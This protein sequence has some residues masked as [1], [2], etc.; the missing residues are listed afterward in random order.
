MHRLAVWLAVVSA[1]VFVPA[2]LADGGP[3]LVT[4][5]GQGVATRDGAFHYVAVPD[6]ARTLLEK[7][8]VADGQVNYWLPLKG[9]WGIPT[10][11]TGSQIGQGLSWNGRT[12]VLAEP[13]GY[14][15][16]SRFLLVDLKRLRAV[17]TITLHGFFSFDALSPDGS[18]MYLIQ[19]SH[20][21]T[22]NLSHYSVR[23]YDLRTNRLLPGKIA[24]RDEDGDEPTMAGYPLTRTT[25]ADGRWVYTLY[26]KP[27][28]MPFVHALDT[29]AGVAHCIDLPANR[30]LYNVVLSLR[31]HDRTLAV[32][33]RSGRPWLDV[34][35]GSWRI[36]QPGAGFPW[37]WA[38]AAI[39][40]ALTLL[41]AG[42]LLLWRRRRQELEQH[43][44]Q[45]L[46]LA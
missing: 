43:A 7:L 8:Q 4:Q 35:V 24:A 11:G 3:F 17:R 19:Y 41:A 46:G 12:L 40:G 5:G 39:A 31:N 2:A 22:G 9:S 25:S 36:S 23:E 37:A 32:H 29:V 18:R 26:Q 33:W 30:G 6:G 21:R 42:A 13:P 27:S 16:P 10:L 20:G 1:L 15:S 34:A 14:W 44:G 45:E 38:G 28:G